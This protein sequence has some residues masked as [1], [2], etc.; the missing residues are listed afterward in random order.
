MPDKLVEVDVKDQND[1]IVVTIHET[2][3]KELSLRS[4][5]MF[6]PAMRVRVSTATTDRI[7]QV[8]HNEIAD[9]IRKICGS[10]TQPKQVINVPDF[11]MRFRGLAI[12]GYT[13]LVHTLDDGMRQFIV[14]LKRGVG[15]AMS[16]FRRIETPESG[17]NVLGDAP[18]GVSANQVQV[19]RLFDE[20][21]SHL[22]LPLVNLNSYLRAS[23]DGETDKRD[24]GLESSVVRLKTKAEVLQ[25]AFD[26][27]IS[28]MMLEKYAAGSDRDQPNTDLAQ[29]NYARDFGKERQSA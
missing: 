26:R 1:Q 17:L 27:L 20:M 22:Y 12:R 19:G 4:V 10:A 7:E 15:N 6:T 16:L 8:F 5:D 21:L 29:L 28:E 9:L 24:S 23:L 18:E 25:F 2:P 13:L 14:R 3:Q 11:T